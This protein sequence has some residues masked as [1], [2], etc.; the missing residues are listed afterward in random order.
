MKKNGY[1]IIRK[2]IDPQLATFV[3]DYFLVKKQ[4][5]DTFFKTRFISPFTIEHGTMGD[6][7]CPDSYSHYADIAM[8]ILLIWL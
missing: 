6:G 4:V 3:H 1:Q 5:A 7:Q 8:E 2:A